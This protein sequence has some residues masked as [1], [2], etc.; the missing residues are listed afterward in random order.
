MK[1]TLLLLVAF[2][3]SLKYRDWLLIAADGQTMLKR[4]WGNRDGAARGRQA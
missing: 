1:P 2:L 3:A 4:K